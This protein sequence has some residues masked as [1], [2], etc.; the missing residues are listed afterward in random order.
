[1]VWVAW[2]VK[3]ILFGD[4]TLLGLRTPF[5]FS[6]PTLEI[7][8]SSRKVREPGFVMDRSCEVE[9]PQQKL[10]KK[11]LYKTNSSRFGTK[12]LEGIT[13]ITI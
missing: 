10:R 5:F 2:V 11:A 7:P 8:S 13:Y 4:R 12:I 1:M 6:Q 9:F 3:K